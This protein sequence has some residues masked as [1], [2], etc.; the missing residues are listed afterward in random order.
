MD[1][2]LDR[3]LQRYRNALDCLRSREPALA[4]FGLL[5]TLAAVLIADSVRQLQNAGQRQS[6]YGEAA[7]AYMK[8]NLANSLT[9]KD[10]AEHLGYSESRT[11]MLI[12]EYAGQSPVDFLL[13]LRIQAAE[14]MLT[15]SPCSISDVAFTCGFNSSQYF[16]RIFRKYT[17]STPTDYRRKNEMT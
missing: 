2:D 17:G 7:L 14:E 3:S 1:A 8:E 9:L 11:F 16:S 10:I 5:R 4:N 12:K 15:T 6:V 13:R